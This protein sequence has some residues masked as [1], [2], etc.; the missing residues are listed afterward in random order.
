MASPDT[1]ALNA[2]AGKYEQ[3]L[4]ATVRN[5]MDILKDITVIPGIKNSFNL[6][7]LSVGNGVRAYRETFDAQD[8]DLTYSGRQLTVELLK[9]DMLINP[10]KY[11]STWMS[12]V[13]SEGINPTEIPFAAFISEQVAGKIGQEVN[14][15]AYLAKKEDGSAVSKSFDGLGTIIA[16]EITA[17]NITPVATGAITAS[18]A[19]EKFST[20]MK[21]MPTAYRL[22]GFNVYCAVDMFDKYSE[23][24]YD[25]F[26][27]YTESS[28]EG[29]Y[30]IDNTAKKV[31]LLP[32]SWLGTSQRIIATPKENLLAGVDGLGDM[33]KIL[34]DTELE[35][36][37]WR[38]LFALGFQIR[39]LDA[40][41]VN[42]Q[43]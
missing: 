30:Y 33:D 4:F 8:S 23:N 1:T 6:T 38:W 15:S 25:K 27:K 7:K 29:H 16:K 9:R 18:N 11:R 36:L 5:S 41:R 10:V 35:I 14:D 2:Y 39:D 24:Y 19:V 3:K 13:M 37:K 43:D 40:I 26:K 21:A 17:K 42:D 31:C 32:C 12:E 20:M 22:A 28:D 34:T